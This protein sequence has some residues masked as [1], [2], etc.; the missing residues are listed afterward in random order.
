MVALL[1]E[2]WAGLLGLAVLLLWPGLLVVRA[3][4]PFV[5]GCTT[6]DT[7]VADLS[8]NAV[9]LVYPNPC[10][11]SITIRFNS[12]QEWVRIELHDTSG[13]LVQV[14]LDGNQAE[15]IHNVPVDVTRLAEGNYVVAV[16]KDSGEL[17]TKLMRVDTI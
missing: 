1:A 5:G 10:I 12:K 7:Q 6:T 4:W 13:R 16:R 14:L 3:P 2:P 8:G 11:D 17:R 9:V 15:G